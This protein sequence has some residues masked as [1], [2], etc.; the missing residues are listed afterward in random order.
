[1]KKYIYLAVALLVS[2]SL[3][4]HGENKPGPNGGFIRMP[5][6][7]HTE[8]VPDKRD[9]SFRLYLLDLE[10]KNPTTKDSSVQASLIQGQGKEV[11]FACLVVVG[12]HFHCKPNKN[13]SMNN[14][15]LTLK[16]KRGDVSGVSEYKFPLKSPERPDSSHQM[17]HSNH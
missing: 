9:H 7:F 2:P 11:G 1:M 14:G 3:F 15:V 8:V 10:F 16:V 6:A 12:S 4:G 5:G 13:Y 17:D